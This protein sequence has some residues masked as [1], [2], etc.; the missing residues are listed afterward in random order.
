MKHTTQYN[1]IQ[2]NVFFLY[3]AISFR[4]QH[5][6]IEIL[7]MFAI[8]CEYTMLLHNQFM[9]MYHTYMLVPCTCTCTCMLFFLCMKYC[10]V[11]Y[12]FLDVT[13]TCKIRNLT[14]AIINVWYCVWKH[15][16]YLSA[17]LYNVLYY[18]TAYKHRT[19]IQVAYKHVHLLCN[20]YKHTTL[21]IQSRRHAVLVMCARS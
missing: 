2:Y 16:Q 18:C 14:C 4:P 12:L 19:C 11:V 21:Y 15:C 7:Y 17:V 10:I 9:Y 8:P 20:M 1:T 3:S 13:C 6:G 5:K